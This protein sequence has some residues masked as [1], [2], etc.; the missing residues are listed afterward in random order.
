MLILIF[1]EKPTRNQFIKL[2]SKCV[3]VKQ[4]LDKC[5]KFFI[6][7]PRIFNI[8]YGVIYTSS[9]LIIIKYMHKKLVSWRWIFWWECLFRIFYWFSITHE[10]FKTQCLIRPTMTIYF[11]IIWSQFSGFLGHFYVNICTCSSKYALSILNISRKKIRCVYFF[12]E[13]IFFSW[14]ENIHF[15]FI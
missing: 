10:K 9:Y 7:F 11:T 2:L 8:F 5:I 15:I 4:H 6:K 13:W 12:T 14:F 3:I 1:Y